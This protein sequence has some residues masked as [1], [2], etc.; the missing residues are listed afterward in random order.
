[1]TKRFSI[2]ERAYL[3]QLPAISN[4]TENRIMYTK[5][6]RNECMRR[7]LAG[8]SATAVFREAGMPPE[9][10]GHKR[11]ERCVA[12][13]RNNCS[14]DMSESGDLDTIDDGDESGLCDVGQL[15]GDVTQKDDCGDVYPDVVWRLAR[16]EE[17]LGDCRRHI[18]ELEAQL[19]QLQQ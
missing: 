7:Y 18:K 15:N 6:F 19:D 12:R 11:I 1:M 17:M 13:W 10:I 9:L 4:V 2:N 14:D 5:A 3:R 8:E 16:L